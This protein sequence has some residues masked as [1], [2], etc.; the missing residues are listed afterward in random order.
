M[1]SN[2]TFNIQKSR[3]VA[4][5]LYVFTY[6]SPLLISISGYW[7][8]SGEHFPWLAWD[9]KNSRAAKGKRGIHLLSN[10]YSSDYNF[11]IFMIMQSRCL[12]CPFLDVLN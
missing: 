11:I 2:I 6:E 4:K 3:K 9:L 10:L 12:C 5:E 1:S 8:S 7:D